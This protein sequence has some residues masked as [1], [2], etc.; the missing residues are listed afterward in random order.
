LSTKKTLV[1][2]GKLTSGYFWVSC[3]KAFALWWQLFF[4]NL[5]ILEIFIRGFRDLQSFHFSEGHSEPGPTGARWRMNGKWSGNSFQL[6]SSCLANRGGYLNAFF[7]YLPNNNPQTGYYEVGS[8]NTP[9]LCIN[10]LLT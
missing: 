7:Y 9:Y 1:G 10:H 3:G 6:G 8:K 5:S 4:G 2:G